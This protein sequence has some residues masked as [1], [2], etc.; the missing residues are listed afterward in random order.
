M[1]EDDDDDEDEDGGGNSNNS[2]AADEDLERRIKADNEKERKAAEARAR[3]KARAAA[4][5]E[6]VPLSAEWKKAFDRVIADA[7]KLPGSELHRIQLKDPEK[8]LEL[9]KTL[10]HGAMGT[11]WR[12]KHKETGYEYAVK[13]LTPSMPRADLIFHKSANCPHV[14]SR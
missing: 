4:A 5:K 14:C 11:V 7:G 2:G 13:Q 6:V 10:G 8:E 3:K 1:F 9:I 12:V